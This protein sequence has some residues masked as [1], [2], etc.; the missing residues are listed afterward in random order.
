MHSACTLIIVPLYSCF[1]LQVVL[2]EIKLLNSGL[3]I[4]AS[5]DVYVAQ[6]LQLSPPS[7]NLYLTLLE[8]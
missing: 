7:Y 8:V 6:A 3:S 2:R 4:E 5:V 1:P